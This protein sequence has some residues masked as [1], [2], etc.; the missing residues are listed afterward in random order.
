MRLMTKLVGQHPNNLPV[1]NFIIKGLAQNWEKSID[2]LYKRAQLG[3]YD[4]P[5]DAAAVE[6]PSR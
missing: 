5:E 4:G 2:G 1:A 6:Q 3:R